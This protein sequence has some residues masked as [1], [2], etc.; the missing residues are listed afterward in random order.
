MRTLSVVV[1]CYKVE[2]WLERCLDSLLAQ[3]LEGLEIVC[4]NDGSPDRC[5]EILREYEERQG[6]GKIVVID[7][8]N[9]GVWKARQRGIA[10]ASGEYI[11][12][13]DPDDYVRPDYARRLYET[14]KALD[15]DIACCGFDRI[16]MATGKR[17]GREMTAFPYGFF[18]FQQEPGLMPEVNAAIWN[19]IF[20]AE[21][22]REMPPFAHIPPVL[23]DFIFLQLIYLNA[24]RIAFTG[25]SL[26]CYMVRG[27]SIIGS[28]K[29]G[30]IPA[31]YE[32]AKELRAIYEHRRA[33]LLPYLDAVAFLHL[34]ISMM[35]RVSA[36]G[37]EALKS[38]LRENQAFLDAEFPL[39]RRSPYLRLSYV[40]RHRGANRKLSTVYRIYRLHLARAFLTVYG[41]TTEKFGV[42]LKW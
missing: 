19:K 18:D 16:D 36:Q 27:D 2:Q 32:A 29:T 22:L 5:L 15:A 11:G 35:H 10:A 38:A 6:D 34:G 17:L 21:L 33:E 28:L 42:S 41:K 1:P 23:D 8:E 4:V 12:F 3:D 26:I 30:Q 24:R 9:A 39:W 13:V 14:A 31:V 40:L 37:Q 7:Q 25:E 20:R